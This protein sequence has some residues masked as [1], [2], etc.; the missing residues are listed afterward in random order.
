MDRPPRRLRLPGALGPRLGASGLLWSPVRSRPRR[1]RPPGWPSSCG[2]GLP[3]QKLSG[4]SAR[5]A[6]LAGALLP[7]LSGTNAFYPVLIQSR[8]YL[9]TAFACAWPGDLGLDRPPAKPPAP[10][11]PRPPSRR[12]RLPCGPA[13]AP[14]SAS[15]APRSSVRARRPPASTW[16]LPVQKLL[17]PSGSMDFQ[18]LALIETYKCRANL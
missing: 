18:R 4:G 5:F 12:L 9:T 13:L 3:A 6:P 1:P 7:P 11:R 15:C 16:L 14:T 2:P 8:T 17:V 10:R